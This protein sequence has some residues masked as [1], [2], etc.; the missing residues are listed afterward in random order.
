MN[1]GSKRYINAFAER[2]TLNLFYRNEKGEL[3]RDKVEAPY[4]AFMKKADWELSGL[5]KGE[6]EGE[7]VRFK[8]YDWDTRN[9]FVTTRN[10]LTFYEAD[11]SAVRRFLSDNEL[12][13][14]KPRRLYFDLETDSRVAFS[15]K[16]NARILSWAICD[17]DG[18]ASSGILTDDT[19]EAEFELVKAF[20]MACRPYDQLIAWNGDGFDFPVIMA[21]SKYLRMPFDVRRFLLL[22]H[23]ALFKRMNTAAESGE[24]KQS[25]KL[26]DIAQAILGE[27]KDEFDG[28]KTWEAWAAGGEERA[29]LLKYNERDTALLPMIEKKNGFIDLFFTLCEVCRVFPNSKGLDPMSQVDGFMIRL[30]VEKQTKFKT[31]RY[32]AA[33]EKF[34]GAYVMEPSLKGIGESVHVADFASLYPSI[35]ITWNMSPE[36]KN[37]EGAKATAPGTEIQFSTDHE[38]MLPTALKSLLTLRKEWSTKQAALPPGTPLWSEAGRKSTAYK[39]AANSFYGVIGS[40]YSR[41]FD[42]QVAESIT[43]A[44]QWLIKQTIEQAAARGMPTVYADTDSCYIHGFSRQV[45]GD[46]VNWCNTEFYPRILKERGCKENVVKLAYEKEFARIVFCAKKR[47]IATFVHY[48]GKEATAD[49]KPEIKGLEYKRSDC[50]KLARKLQSQVIDI[51]V[52]GA[53]TPQEFLSILSDMKDYILCSPL[54]LSEVAISKSISKSLEEYKTKEKKDGTTSQ[55]LAHVGVAKERQSRGLDVS[56]GSRVPFVVVDA[57]VSPMKVIDADFYTGECDRHYLWEN[58]VYP[59]SGRLL[60]AMFPEY[61]WSIW[62]KSRPPKPRKA[63]GKSLKQESLL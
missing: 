59:P 36:T 40:P 48:K 16:E 4:C 6:V 47:Y 43:Q 42:R 9:E 29:R 33:Q 27:T 28:S 61:E 5:Q 37:A 50:A 30:A 2:D 35:I 55:D 23:L 49:S 56:I 52:K 20:W 62:E 24:E 34:E 32:I 10:N 51:F 14:V 8:F 41:Y 1:Q 11:I 31:R 22:D 13:I 46:F 44:G 3:K 26:G 17:D 7:W 18:V 21:R 57:S 39:V 60:Q 19:D 53:D 12:E 15:K 45:F 54:D 25:F 63:R 58:L 38:G